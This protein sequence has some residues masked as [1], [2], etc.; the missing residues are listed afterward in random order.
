MN[1]HST[2]GVAAQPGADFYRQLAVCRSFDV[3]GDPAAFTPLPDDWVVIIGDIRDSTPAIA[4]GRYKD[5]NMVGAA[6]IVAALNAAPE[7]DLPYVFGGDGATLAVP[8]SAVAA[9]RTALLKTRALAAQSFDMDLRVGLVPLAEL[10]ARGA[11]VAVARL[12]ISPGNHLALFSGVGVELADRLIKADTDGA[13]GFSITADAEPDPDLEGLSCRWEPLGAERGHMVNLLIRARAADTVN[14]AALYHAVVDDLAEILRADPL[15]GRPVRVGN[16]RFRWPPRS[17][18]TEAALT[19]GGRPRWRRY[20]EIW[21]E[22]LIQLFLERFDRSA[23][24]YNAPVYRAEL[25][26]NTDFRRFDGM[27]RMVVDCTD[28]ELAGLRAMLARRHAGGELDYGVHV[29]DAAL[30]T[31]LVF[32]LEESRHLHFIDG[33]DGGFAAAATGLKAQLAEVAQRNAP[34]LASGTGPA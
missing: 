30:M 8:S 21:F 5:V 33:A 1:R 26:A 9:V 25:R 24:G 16:L 13:M 18:G 29:A 14:A 31:C 27:L 17:L 10:R 28:G 11:D 23:G 7:C 32:D 4:A 19:R 3:V 6:C 20:L 15:A 22:S 34:P 12:E 2:S